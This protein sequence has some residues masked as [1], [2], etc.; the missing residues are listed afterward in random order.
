[1][2]Y[3]LWSSPITGYR[4]K[5][6]RF[7]SIKQLF[8]E[9]VT[10]QCIYEPLLSC[11]ANSDSDHA[12]KALQLRD[13]DVA[14][15]KETDDGPIIG[16]VEAKDIGGESFD[17]Y[18]KKI[19]LNL[20]LTESTPIA[21]LINELANKDFVFVLAGSKI[22]GILTK[23]DINKPPVRIYIFGIISLF[24]MHLNLWITHHYPDDSWENEVA[25]GRVTTA[26]AI[27]EERKGNNLELSLLECLQFCDKRDILIKSEKF[28]NK[29]NFSKNAFEKL[30]K[31]AEKIRN[32]L[33]HSQ[34]S[35]I[36]N[37]VWKN[38]V[39]TL[40]E[41]DTFLIR[42]DTE[43]EEIARVGEEF[44]DILI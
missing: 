23:A 17:Q 5:G 43:I 16:Y 14:G 12:K 19:G 37:I 7:Q 32:E 1:M 42:S 24:E 8:I 34:N 18:I 35:I 29:F 22:T 36:A 26:K 20:V 9:N 33:A 21:D 4:R 13:F 15:V 2:S 3:Q 6:T 41:I 40:S 38:F 28:L 11:P 25:E 27:Y 39:L 44:Q 10:A 31:S 30:L